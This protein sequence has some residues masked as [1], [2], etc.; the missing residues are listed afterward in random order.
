M[1]TILAA[2]VGIVVALIVQSACDALSS[3]LY[4]T[5]IAD[6]WNRTQVAEALANRPAAA[7]WISVAGYLLGGLAGG[8]LGKMISRTP[9]AAWVPAAPLAAMAAVIGLSFPAPAWSSV[10]NVAAALIGAMLSNH[11][12]ATR[13]AAARTVDVADDA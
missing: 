7:L 4:P 8:T 11:L 9:V 13:P 3:L 10:A 6:M 5:G 12:V 2:I 1:R